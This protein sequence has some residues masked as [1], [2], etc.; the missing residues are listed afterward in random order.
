MGEAFEYASGVAIDSLC[1][2]W[3]AILRN[4]P[5]QVSSPL[6]AGALLS[7]KWIPAAIYLSTIGFNYWAAMNDSN[8][9]YS[10]AQEAKKLSSEAIEEEKRITEDFNRAKTQEQKNPFAKQMIHAQ[11]KF[12]SVTALALVISSY[13]GDISKEKAMGIEEALASLKIQKRDSY[14][15]DVQN[16]LSPHTTEETKTVLSNL[17]KAAK[18]IEKGLENSDQTPLQSGEEELTNQADEGGEGYM[19]SLG[20]CEEGK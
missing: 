15:V 4:I 5:D 20:H 3:P 10:L 6:L 8:E 9:L 12:L 19:N 7:V 18:V 17:V 1:L 13:Q 11:V 14:L 2:S 16:L